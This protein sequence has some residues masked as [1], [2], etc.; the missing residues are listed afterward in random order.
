MNPYD[1]LVKPLLSEKSNR[2]RENAGK[3]T[4]EI[5]KDATKTDVKAAVEKMFEV[6]VAGVTTSNNRGKYRR[7]GAHWSNRPASSKK[8]VV[9]LVDG[10]KIPLFE[11]L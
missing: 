9:T 7:R 4:F 10:A 1:V 5:R 3:Y 8:A 2:E 6:K 11:D